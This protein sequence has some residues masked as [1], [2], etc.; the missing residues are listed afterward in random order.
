MRAAHEVAPRSAGCNEDGQNDAAGQHSAA[1]RRVTRASYGR[2]SIATAA[3]AAATATFALLTACNGCHRGAGKGDSGAVQTETGPATFRLYVLSDLAGALEPCGCQK[4]MLGGVDH[5]GALVAKEHD[6][7]KD[8]AV[9]T[10]GPTFFMDE[11]VKPE[12]LE[13]DGWKAE[14]IAAGLKPSGLLAITPG[15][16][17]WGAGAQTLGKL[18]DACGAALLGANLAGEASVGAVAKTTRDYGGVK[19]TFLGVSVPKSNKGAPEGLTIEDATKALAAAAKKARAE[20]ARIVIGSAALDRGDAIRAAEAAPE[21]D[22]LAVGS[23]FTDGEAN[24]NPKPP[25]FVGNVLVVQPS[26]HLTRV[27]VVDLFVRPGPANDSG[28]FADGS[29]LAHAAEVTDLETQIDDLQK[30]IANWEKDPTVPKSDLDAQK[31]RIEA[32]RNKLAKAKIPPPTPTGSFLRYQLVDVREAYGREDKAWTAMKSYYQRVNKFNEEKFKD[33]KAPP[34]PKGEP[35]YV[36]SESC[37]PCHAASFA[38][39]GKTGHSHAYKTLTDES[40]EFN[41]DCVGCHVTGYD[42][43]GGS[44]VTDVVS[45]NLKDVQCESCHG[46]GSQHVADP[47]SGIPVSDPGEQVCIGCHHPPHTDVFDFKARRDKVLGPGHGKPGAE[48]NNDPPKG[49]KPPKKRF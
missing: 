19:V 34:P 32:M 15:K 4:D 26:N 43:P 25:R 33:K 9:I 20:G 45:P 2:R 29:G 30:R 16:N 46:P 27:A 47:S 1:M 38:V 31:K 18:R 21:L 36:G 12:R 13:Q 37:N 7:A 11:V 39:W 5:F 48:P 28:R 23:P 14:A 49:W 22:V 8:S 6:K 40:K 41:L 24:D 44:T 35:F 10:V 3:F 17:D 42:Q